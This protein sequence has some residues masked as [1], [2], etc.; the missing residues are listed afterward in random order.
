V[1]PANTINLNEN[2]HT[3]TFVTCL[4]GGPAEIPTLSTW[5]RIVM[6]A[7]LAGGGLLALRR[8]PV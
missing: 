4:A 7:L 2:T 6:V 1:V 8:G 3:E 5:A